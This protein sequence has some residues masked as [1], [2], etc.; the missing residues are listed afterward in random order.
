MPIICDSR[1]RI[2]QAP[3]F[4]LPISHI[5]ECFPLLCPLVPRELTSSFH[6]STATLTAG[7]RVHMSVSPDAHLLSVCRLCFFFW[8]ELVF[9][10][11][12]WLF[13]MYVYPLLIT[14]T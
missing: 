13:C 9:Y 11:F 10:H 4:L 7:L 8:L 3:N 14:I 2:H 6:S 1:P 5:K 12:V